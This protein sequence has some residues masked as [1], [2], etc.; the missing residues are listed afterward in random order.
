MATATQAKR[1]AT[2]P[3]MPYHIVLTATVALLMLGLVIVTSAS[4]V[5]SYQ[6]TGSSYSIALKQALFG[7]IG[8]LG[9]WY[10]AST[11][12]ATIRRLAAPYFV[13][14]IAA[15]GAVLFIGTSING[16]RNWIQIIGP[17]NLQPSE[18]TKLGVILWGAH[19]L[20][21]GRAHV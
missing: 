13:G 21:I 14:C 15:L 9:M 6:R 4:S 1:K 16:Q 12:P 8:C 11:R 7:A 3:L 2:H 10:A 19:V 5:Y 18:F 17:F 20:E